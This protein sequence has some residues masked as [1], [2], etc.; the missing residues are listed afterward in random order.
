MYTEEKYLL[1][2]LLSHRTI[3]LF[4]FYADT[5]F[6]T[7][8]IV[9]TVLKYQRKGYLI[10]LGKVIIRTPIGSLKLRRILREE[11]K[12]NCRYWAQVPDEYLKKKIPI[13]SPFDNIRINS[14]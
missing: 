9:R 1:M 14:K 10:F 6:S 7:G 12:N 8:Q 2:A 5:F 3:N 11:I 4:D 13:N